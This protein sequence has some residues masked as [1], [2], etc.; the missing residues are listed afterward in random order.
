MCWLGMP[1]LAIAQPISPVVIAETA[2]GGNP[3][4]LFSF[5]GQRPTN[6]GAKDGQFAPCPGTPNC[7][8]S[9]AAASD[10]EH[11]IESIAYTS[12]PTQ[13]LA[14]LKA[15]IQE[16]PRTAIITESGSYIY[17]EFQSALMGFVDDVEFYLDESARTIHVRSASRL[18]KSDLG[19]NRKRIEAIRTRFSELESLV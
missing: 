19:V 11:K 7:V 18:G 12:S 13:A 4:S 5:A 10:Q 9:Q 1:T 16:M 3:V 8:S 6:L 2:S 15:V 14:N 17:A